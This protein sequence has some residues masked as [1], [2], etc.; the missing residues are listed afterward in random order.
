M[1]LSFPS[2]VLF[3]TGWSVTPPK[4]QMSMRRN[5]LLCPVSCCFNG[6]APLGTAKHV[7]LTEPPPGLTTRA[8]STGERL[9]PPLLPLCSWF[10]SW[11]RNT[12]RLRDLCDITGSEPL[13]RH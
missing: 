6:V 1:E 4:L 9:Q 3:R 11:R 10:C 5:Y 12:G 2:G 7:L 13:I 8:R